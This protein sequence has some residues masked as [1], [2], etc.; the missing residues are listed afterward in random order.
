MAADAGQDP[1]ADID[2][3]AYGHGDPGGSSDGYLYSHVHLDTEPFAN[4]QSYGYANRDIVADRHFHAWPDA[5]A[6]K[7]SYADVDANAD[8]YAYTYPRRYAH[9]NPDA[10][11]AS[12][13]QDG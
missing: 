8:R 3:H 12:S 7:H 10:H 5:D 4:K 1:D 11:V 9:P 2:L 13:W 6:D